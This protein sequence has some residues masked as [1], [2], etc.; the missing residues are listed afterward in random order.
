MAYYMPKG[1]GKPFTSRTCEPKMVIV[2]KNPYVH[3]LGGSPLNSHGLIYAHLGVLHNR[4]LYYIKHQRCH[5]NDIFIFETRPNLSIFLMSKKIVRCLLLVALDLEST[6]LVD[7]M[8]RGLDYMRQ[9]LE[10]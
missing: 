3:I 5:M 10:S 6:L 7:L 8:Q 1:L 9:A 4:Y 2:F